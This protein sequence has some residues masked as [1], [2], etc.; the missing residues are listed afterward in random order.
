MY[1]FN[2]LVIQI[3]VAQVTSSIASSLYFVLSV[4]MQY[5]KGK[6]HFIAYRISMESSL[7]SAIRTYKRCI[8]I[9][10]H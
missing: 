3:Y 10:V 7:L 5:P 8:L 6:V 2:V 1:I 4:A 9:I